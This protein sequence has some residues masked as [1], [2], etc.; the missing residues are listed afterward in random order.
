MAPRNDR[1]EMRGLLL[2]GE[3]L[4]PAVVSIAA[5]HNGGRVLEKL[6]VLFHNLRR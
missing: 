1:Q 6:F 5:S 4:V 2:Q 3:T